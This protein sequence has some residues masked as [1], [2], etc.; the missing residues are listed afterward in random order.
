M[1]QY[2]AS[3]YQKFLVYQV[4]GANTNVG[5]TIFS[6]IVCNAAKRRNQA[7]AVW[8]LKPVSTGPKNEADKW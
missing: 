6:T 8:Y 3:L 4:F 7:G 1:A 2:G 5:K